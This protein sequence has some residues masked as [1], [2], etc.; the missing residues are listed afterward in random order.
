MLSLSLVLI[1]IVLITMLLKSSITRD[2]RL[3]L[4][5]KLTECRERVV[6]NILQ[7]NAAV[8]KGYAYDYG[9]WDQMVDFVTVKKDLDWAHDELD[10]ALANYKIDYVWVL[11]ST[12]GGYYYTSINKSQPVTAL[13]I[14]APRLK[15]VF[16]QEPF[17]SFFVRHNNDL[18]E[19]FSS[20]VQPTADK[21]RST[22]PQGY[23]L[24]GRIVDSLYMANL[25]GISQ[26]TAIRYV[27]AND[28]TP[29]NIDPGT[30]LLQ[31]SMP[32]KDI[33]GATLA[34]FN[35]E[36]S[37]PVL[38]S[39]QHYLNIYLLLFLGLIAAVVIFFYSRVKK[40]VLQPLSL[41]STALRN[42][43]AIHINRYVHK[44]NEIGDLSRLIVDFFEQNKIMEEEV[45]IRKRSEADLI[46]ALEE[47]N[48]AESER[49]R[50]EVFLG[51]QQEVLQ[52]N[53]SNADAG[54][55][56]ILNDM[57][58]MAAR[59][60]Q[61]ERVG[62][63]LYNDDVSSIK[64]SSIY[65]LSTNAF[66]DGGVSYEKE[67][68]VYFSHLKKDALIVASDAIHH[69]ATLEF[70]E[71][72]LKPMGITSMLDVPIRNGNRVIGVVCYEH[73][74]PQ[75]EW[76]ISEQVFAKSLSDIIALNFEREERKKVEDRLRKSKIR[77]EET[78]ELAHIGSWEYNFVTHE[79]VWSG[80]MYRIF[81]M[82]DTPAHKLFDAF[83]QRIHKEDMIAFDGA[84]S[85]LLE[86]GES[87]STEVRLI[88][89][90]GE[91]KYILA[92]GDVIR[93]HRQGKVV[94]MRGTVQDITKQKQAAMAK[95]EFLSCMSHEI[96]TPIN[97]VIGIAS[98]LQDEDLNERQQ[99]YVRTLNFTAQHLSA[100]VS[101]ILDFSKIESGHM[102]FE[103]ASFNLDK[104]CHDILN[105]FAGKAEEKNIAVH[106]NPSP[107]SDYSLY[108]DYVRLNQVLSN[109]LSNA[110]KFTAKGSVTLSYSI[111]H[112]DRHRVKICFNVKD[113]GI[114]IPEKQQ[115]QI[116]ESFTQA[117]E[118]ITRQYGGTGL[119]LT[120][121]KKLIEL[122]GGTI[123]LS[124][125]EGE[126]SEFLVTL[127][128]EKHVYN[129]NV[130]RT[131]TTAEKNNTKDLSGMRILV[132]EDNNVN[133]MVLTRFLSKWKIES[134]VVKDGV[135]ALELLNRESF[136]LVLM[137]IQMPVMDGIE[138]TIQIR[139]SDKP[140]LR[141]IPVVAFTADA[142]L[143]THR[144][145]IR[146]G[147][148]HCLTKP[149]NPE[150]LFSFLKKQY[151]TQ[152][153]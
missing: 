126:G 151:E 86:S 135:E 37:Y 27:P 125:R 130:L 111:L 113:T 96:R 106:F 36:R 74:G 19:V 134:S 11:D 149:F 21:T 4:H 102:T 112:E 105:L 10:D 35:I 18:V 5:D 64:A 82:E 127:E 70:A 85:K 142:S 97:G 77:F 138:A 146:I 20:P 143:D 136:D 1:S 140:G 2:T 38:S 116:F 43:E 88:C 15:Q 109:L 83:R 26:E 25:Q 30:G 58:A 17:T 68:P 60:I 61:C 81:C 91:L 107:M 34:A 145:L 84:V 39:Y 41:F 89:P 139:R 53:T 57:V 75:R 76:T 12:A 6:P 7:L 98:L 78:Q 128:F 152:S 55:D 100:I 48:I 114:G 3:L 31:Y 94:G 52:L 141:D 63:W 92:I 133:A 153:T 72:Y 71:D 59:S 42:N 110:I 104:N 103:R 67:Y 8:I 50:A 14:P 150:A 22:R 54:L 80:E 13:H 122:Q 87:Y 129:D 69:A 28:T 121:C 119:G 137:D 23:L 147:F 117:D 65:Q 93:S 123:S 99:E 29:E 115:K 131:I 79:V 47:K 144:E 33:D 32:L 124:S 108:G 120:I 66:V 45:E 46:T 9:V 16:T 49:I 148:N 51:Q 44:P 56:N 73:I 95:S 24:L 101:D 40:L 118:T 90:K 132:A 62:I